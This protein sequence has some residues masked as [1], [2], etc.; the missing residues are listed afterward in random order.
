MYEW[1]AIY[2]DR[3]IVSERPDFT[4]DDIDRTRLK[5]FHMGNDMMYDVETGIFY[6]FGMPLL[7]SYGDVD[8]MNRDN[9]D[10]SNVIQFKRRFND[11]FGRTAILSYRFGYKAQIDNFTVQF[12]IWIKPRQIYLDIHLKPDEVYNKILSVKF[13]DKSIEYRRP[14]RQDCDGNIIGVKMGVT[15]LNAKEIN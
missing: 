12:V 15:L 11:N 10:Y 6:I 3:S 4:F 9:V 7:I 13:G 14:I 1:K 2:K 8:F 5:E